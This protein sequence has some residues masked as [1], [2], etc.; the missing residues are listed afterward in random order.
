MAAMGYA[1]MLNEQP[2]YSFSQ[3]PT[4]QHS[5]PKQHGFYPY[6]ILLITT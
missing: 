3:A 4:S 1:P 2:G 6:V 5:Q